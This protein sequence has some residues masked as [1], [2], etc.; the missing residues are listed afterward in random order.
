V[1]SFHTRPQKNAT[2]QIYPKPDQKEALVLK[3]YEAIYEKGQIRWLKEAPHIATAHIIVTILDENPKII[4][5]RTPPTSLFGKGKVLG[6]I[7]NPIT[8]E[9]DWEC[10]K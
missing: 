6:D 10:L 1:T 8:D 7:I 2:R 4:K 5:R 9:G 3:S